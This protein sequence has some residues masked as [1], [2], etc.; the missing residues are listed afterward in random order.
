MSRDAVLHCFVDPLC[1][2]CH[3]AAPLIEAARPVL[4]VQWH[5]GGLRIG[6]M[7]QPVSDAWQAMSMQHDAR[8]AQI[9][10]QPFGAA[11]TEGLL[12]DRTAI[13]DSEP[14][15]TAMLAADELGGRG[16]DMLLQLQKAHYLDG[17]QIASEAVLVSLA[18]QLG[19]PGE[20][21]RKT[22]RQLAGPMVQRRM[23]ASRALMDKLGA[24]GYPSFVVEAGGQFKRLATGA[25]L[26][27]PNE[28]AAHLKTLAS[29]AALRP[30]Q[31]APAWVAASH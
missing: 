28:F 18:S 27:R 19:L 8:I 30:V 10:G 21:F 26:G 15:I 24:P 12:N 2:W 29:I 25:Y 16:L 1:G 20:R 5:A 14:P 7:A 17:Q 31:G 13:L 9:T 6:P 4:H 23:Q 22:L 11:Y 3:G